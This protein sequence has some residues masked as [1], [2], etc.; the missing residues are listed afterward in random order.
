[1]NIV[2]KKKIIIRP[3]YRRVSSQNLTLLEKKII[4]ITYPHIARQ[5]R[6]LINSLQAH[7]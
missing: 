4:D 6:T 7:M 2:V 1:M 3:I 5:S